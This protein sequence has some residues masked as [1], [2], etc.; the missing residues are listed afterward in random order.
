METTATTRSTGRPDQADWYLVERP[1]PLVWASACTG[2][3]L[4][5][6]PLMALR[7]VKRFGSGLVLLSYLPGV[8]TAP[9]AERLT[10]R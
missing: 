8:F 7:D 10:Q 5:Q 9:S 3:A 4:M 1:N 6:A 2:A